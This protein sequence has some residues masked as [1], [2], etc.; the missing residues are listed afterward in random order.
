[1]INAVITQC[2]YVN[3]RLL[4]VYILGFLKCKKHFMSDT[5]LGTKKIN[6]HK[7]HIN[8]LLCEVLVITK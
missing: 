1:M 7:K 4:S 6:N 5:L 8:L 3:L 2:S